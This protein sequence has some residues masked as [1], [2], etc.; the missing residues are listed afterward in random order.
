MIDSHRGSYW[1]GMNLL[2]QSSL[3]LM[4]PTRYI[5]AFEW[6][7][8]PSGWYGGILDAV[9]HRRLS[10]RTE[11]TSWLVGKANGASHWEVDLRVEKDGIFHGVLVGYLLFVSW[12]IT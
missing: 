8:K 12:S 3:Y 6:V 1:I 2:W 11:V 7:I 10:K 4:H 9:P 5:G